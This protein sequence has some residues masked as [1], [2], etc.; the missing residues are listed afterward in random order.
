MGVLNGLEDIPDLS[1]PPLVLREVERVATLEVDLDEDKAL[2]VFAEDGFKEAA[3]AEDL[4]ENQ[5]V[6]GGQV[7]EIVL[8]C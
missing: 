7:V 3:A 4:D 2:V 6:G 5:V 1:Q 8:R